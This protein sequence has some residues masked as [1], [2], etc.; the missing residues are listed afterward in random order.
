M[1]YVY[2]N[3]GILPEDFYLSL[4]TFLLQILVDMSQTHVHTQNDCSVLCNLCL[5]KQKNNY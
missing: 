5:K 3:F 1:V 2:L 4:L